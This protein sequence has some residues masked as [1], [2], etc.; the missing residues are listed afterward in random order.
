MLFDRGERLE[1]FNSTEI[2]AEAVASV[3]GFYFFFVHI[4][5]MK[6][7]SLD[8]ALFKDRN[9]A[10]GVGMMFAT[11]TILVSSSSLMAPWLQNLANYPVDTAGLIMAPRGIGTMV[12]MVLAGR[13]AGFTPKYG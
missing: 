12:A 6:V 9:F 3:L 13:I 4:L 7:H 5:T 11:G 8:K 1:W 2:W 10:T